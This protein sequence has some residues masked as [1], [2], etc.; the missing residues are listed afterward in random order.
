MSAPRPISNPNQHPNRESWLNDVASR[1]RPAFV[2][3]GAP[4]P[5]RLRIAIGFPSTGRRAKAT[6]E[7]WDSTASADGTFEI[8]IRPDLAE[9]DGAIAL[10]VAAALA[11][12]LVQAAVGIQAGKGVVFRRVALG[13]GLTGPMRA[14]MPGPAF[15][16]LVAPILETVG[17]LP[18][19]RLE[20]D[21]K[22]GE[23]DQ[24]VEGSLTTTAPRK[25]ANRHVKCTCGTCGYVV[26]TA[27]KWIDDVG[28]PLC[29]QHGPMIAE[30]TTMA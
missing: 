24:Q 21:K 4:L 11:H 9:A 28:A 15:L 8:L 26:R 5:D 20:A 14:T 19:A 10:P 6:G 23:A 18:H 7:C 13:I 17:P 1:L 12:E 30:A 2:Q 29:P 25:Q 27:R 22:A 16:A 3:L